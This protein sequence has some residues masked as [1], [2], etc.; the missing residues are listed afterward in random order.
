MHNISTLFREVIDIHRGR[1]IS[2]AILYSVVER[3]CKE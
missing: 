3:Q 1:Y 2:A